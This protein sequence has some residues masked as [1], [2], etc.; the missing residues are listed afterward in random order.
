MRVSL[1]GAGEKWFR[2]LLAERTD[3][4]H[5]GPAAG[6]DLVFL[7]AE[8]PEDLERLRDLRRRI[9]EN[10]AIWV[11]RIKGAGRTLTESDV[12]EAAARGGLVDNKIASFSDTLGAM[13]LVVR[14]RDRSP[15]G[16]TGAAA[17]RPP[18]RQA[19]RTI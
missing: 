7:R 17:R 2:E 18:P 12:I 13:R 8:V 16:R 1:L 9:K 11:L 5:D 19:G 14:L 4:V 15:S 6:S 3:D 10:G